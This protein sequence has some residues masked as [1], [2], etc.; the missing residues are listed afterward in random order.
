DEIDAQALGRRQGRRLAQERLD[1]VDPLENEL[2]IGVA[3]ALGEFAEKPAAAHRLHDGGG[4]CLIVRFGPRRRRGRRQG[5]MLVGHRQILAHI[6]ALWTPARRR[7]HA[8][9][10]KLERCFRES[11]RSPSQ[12]NDFDG[13]YLG[14]G[15]GAAM[16]DRFVLR[17]ALFY[18]AFFFYLGLSMPFVPAWLAAKGLDAREIGIV[19]A[20]PMVVRVIGVPLATRLA[21]R[22]GMLH[23]ALS[24]A[25]FA[26]VLGFALVGAASGFVPILGT[27]ALAAVVLAPVLPFA[28]ALALRG[29]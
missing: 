17:L 21:D 25:S 27:Y 18:G 4:D 5:E 1:P 14:E 2:G 13:R 19:L 29:L 7:G 16:L 20:A 9:I 28:D 10:N 15:F 8:P 6:P 22:F 24:A 3:V 12:C 23:R 11:A 26:S